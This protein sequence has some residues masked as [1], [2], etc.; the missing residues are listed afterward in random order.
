MT[1][2]VPL[3]TSQLSPR[4]WLQDSRIWRMCVA[5]GPTEEVGG[6]EEAEPSAQTQEKCL[7]DD[8]EGANPQ[9]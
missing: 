4:L 3:Q 6:P 2:N 1:P 7:H 5:T 9:R 8:R